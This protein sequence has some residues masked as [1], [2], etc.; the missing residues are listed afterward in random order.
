MPLASIIINTKKKNIKNR[1][2]TTVK[3]KKKCGNESRRSYWS[4]YGEFLLKTSQAHHIL[5]RH[6]KH[7]T[8]INVPQGGAI[9]HHI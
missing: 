5:L 7:L 3:K 4:N 2:V 1:I 8:K 6:L 9:P